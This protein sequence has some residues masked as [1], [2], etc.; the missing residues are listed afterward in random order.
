MVKS[1]QNTDGKTFK[2]MD[3]LSQTGST[4]LIELPPSLNPPGGA[5]ILAKLEYFN[6][7]GSIKDRVALSMVEAAERQGH[8]SPGSVI[9]EPTSGNTGVALAL[10]A[11]VKGYRLILVMPETMSVERRRLAAAYG[12]ETVLTPA[13]EG[14]KG[15]IDEACRLNALYPGS[16]ILQQ[17]ENPANPECHF[18]T[19]GPEI[20]RDAGGKVDV[21]V[22]A[23]GTGGTFTGTGRYLKEKNPAVELYGVEPAESAVLS[24]DAPGQHAIQGIGAGFVPKVMDVSLLDGVVKVS[25]EEAFD[26]ARLAARNGFF[27]GIS[28]GAALFAARRLSS[29]GKYRGKTIVTVF[30][31]T[32]ERYLSTKLYGEE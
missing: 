18:K 31:D 15:S 22:A 8:L 17:F 14:M 19:T 11:A 32:G 3:I 13:A 25:G 21:F 12:A 6:P 27:C 2:T 26:A 29:L 16:V 9:I 10:V 24:G 4:P 28:S 20:W 23:I 5:R 7:A 1:Q 30:P